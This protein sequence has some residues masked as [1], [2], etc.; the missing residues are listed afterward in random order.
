MFV[1][2]DAGAH[3]CVVFLD[4]EGPAPR[5][6]M[7]K[8]PISIKEIACFLFCSERMSHTG[9]FFPCEKFPFIFL[10][11]LLSGMECNI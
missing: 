4:T 10:G 5:E 7:G 2:E 8:V 11:I 9:I 3:V 1:G 6:K